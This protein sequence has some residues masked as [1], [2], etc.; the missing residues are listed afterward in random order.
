MLKV[1]VCQH[2]TRCFVTLPL[3][4]RKGDTPS[5]LD[6]GLGFPMSVHTG[7]PLRPERNCTDTVSFPGYQFNFT[8]NINKITVCD[9][10]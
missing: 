8:E 2:E 1:R 3:V 5:A 9:I 6:A 7:D 10:K 4:L